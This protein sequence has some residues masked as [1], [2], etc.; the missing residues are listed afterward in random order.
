[1][2]RVLVVANETVE[3]DELLRELRRIEDEK[4]STYHVVAP[5]VAQDHGMGTWSQE[6]AIAAAAERLNR[7]LAILKAEGLDADGHVGD[8]LPLAAIRDAL[9]QFPADRIVISTHPPE[10]SR[11]LRRDL[12][13]KVRSTFGLPVQHIISHTQ[14]PAPPATHKA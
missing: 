6:G 14:Q 3:A 9:I 4:T 13:G 11:W 7:T 5:A 10:R 2:S 8:M 1:M 12:V